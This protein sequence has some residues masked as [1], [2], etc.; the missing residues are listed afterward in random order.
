MVN[1]MALSQ[2]DCRNVSKFPFARQYIYFAA[3]TLYY[4]SWIFWEKAQGEEDQIWHGDKAAPL[5]SS[6]KS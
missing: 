6:N 1:I 2:S 4:E 5:A 3:D